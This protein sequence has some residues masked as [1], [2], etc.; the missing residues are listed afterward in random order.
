M[1]SAEIGNGWAQ[2]AT[3]AS[4]PA[5]GHTY[6]IE[7]GALAFKNE[8]NA[9]GKQ[10]TFTRLSDGRTGTVQYTA[11]E[12]RPNLFWTHWTESDGTSVARIE[13]YERE[14]VHAV[15]HFHDGKVLSLNGTFRKL[16]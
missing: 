14:T 10:M 15:V 2:P 8:F 4:Y 1:W 6:Q 11:V 5:P 9:D 3:S 7:F 16:Q 12:I 13:D